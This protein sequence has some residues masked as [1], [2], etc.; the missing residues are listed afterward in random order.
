M[1]IISKES[2]ASRIAFVLL[3]TPSFLF[4]YYT[5]FLTFFLLSLTRLVRNTFY[6]TLVITYNPLFLFQPM[7]NT[8][9]MQSS[10]HHRP[11]SAFQWPLPPQSELELTIKEI[12]DV[13]QHDPELLKLV[14]SAKA[15]EDKVCV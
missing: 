11:P 10:S 1:D 7:A 9:S 14:L 2:V 13:Y 3:H 6:S 4:A 8:S 15:E 12:L 5:F